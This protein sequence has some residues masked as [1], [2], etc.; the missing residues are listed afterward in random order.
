MNKEEN[1][2]EKSKSKPVKKCKSCVKLEQE[3]NESRAGWQRALADYKNLQREIEEKKSDWVLLS[4]LQILEE[5][6]PVYDNFKKAFYSKRGEV[7]VEQDNWIKGIEYIMKQ[8][9]DIL[10]N[11]DIKSIETTGKK[12]DP[13]YHEAV[14]QEDSDE[15]EGVILREV[16]AGY[17]MKEKVIKPAKVIVS[18]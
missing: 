12:F 7:T 10:K 4:E 8:F 6:I 14:G 18:K 17:T 15:E 5:F 13:K 1:K 11:H 16:D 3:M 9:G 2:K